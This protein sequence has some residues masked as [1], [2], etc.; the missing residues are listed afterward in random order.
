MLTCNGL[1][2]HFLINETVY[3]ALSLSF[4]VKG[5]LTQELM[6]GKCE[7]AET[8]NRCWARE[9]GT[10]YTINPAT[11]QNHQTHSFLKDIKA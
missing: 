8:K 5:L 6:T 7:D 9:L 10:I 3:K 1:R 4:E 2:H 11:Y